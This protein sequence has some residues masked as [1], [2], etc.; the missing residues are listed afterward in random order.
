MTK[1]WAILNNGEYLP[2]VKITDTGT[3]ILLRK[4]NLIRADALR[5][6][7][8]PT[9]TDVPPPSKLRMKKAN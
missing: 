3:A 9:Y 5:N 1:L 6:T 7:Y 4:G 2:V 8:A